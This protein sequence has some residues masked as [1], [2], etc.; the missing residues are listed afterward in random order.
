[1]NVVHSN[2]RLSGGGIFV[3]IHTRWQY[4]L[5]PHRCVCLSSSV[6]ITH[7][8]A[9]HTGH[10]HLIVDIS[11]ESDRTHEFTGISGSVTTETGLIHWRGAEERVLIDE[12]SRISA[13]STHVALAAGGVTVHTVEIEDLSEPFVRIV[14]CIRIPTE[15]DE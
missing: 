9:I 2:F 12:S 4:R 14:E 7:I 1:M 8:V 15:F 13:R 11:S 3:T 10:A 5:V 6:E